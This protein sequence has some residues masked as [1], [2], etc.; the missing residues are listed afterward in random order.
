MLLH[1]EMV[2][3]AVVAGM[4][5]RV[6]DSMACISVRRT[7]CPVLNLGWYPH[8][9]GEGEASHTPCVQM[10]RASKLE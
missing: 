10:Y 2:P 4:V 6:S 7:R 5:A 3:G 9:G 8:C 1:K